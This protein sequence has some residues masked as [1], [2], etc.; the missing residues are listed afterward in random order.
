MLLGLPHHP[1]DISSDD[2]SD[3]NV[4]EVQKTLDNDDVKL[5]AFKRGKK[6]KKKRKGSSSAIEDKEE[7]SPFLRAYKNTCLRIENAAQKISSS[8]EASSAPP[9]TVSL[10]LWRP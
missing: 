9:Q 4:A 1:G 3:D 8:V 2:S 7:R 5:A 6:E 10:A